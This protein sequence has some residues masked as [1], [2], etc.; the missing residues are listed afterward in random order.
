MASRLGVQKFSY[1]WQDGQKCV[2]SRIVLG[3][4]SVS[5]LDM[6]TAYATIANH[7]VKQDPTPV[8]KVTEPDGKVLVDYTQPTGTPV[9]NAAIADTT[10]DLLRGVVEGGTGRRA[11]IGRPAAGKTGTTDN[12]TDIWF[13]GY[14]PQLVAAVWMG[15]ADGQYSLGNIFGGD[16]AAATWAA[17]MRPAMEGQPELDFPAPGPL[18]APKAG[19]GEPARKR[20]RQQSIA[21]FPTDCGGPCV[22]MPELPEPAAPPTTQPTDGSSTTTTKPQEDD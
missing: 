22:R 11:N 9:L 8:V 2:S 14:T 19:A 4:C 20:P 10:T 13:V 5:P 3:Q 18:P 16:L 17:F 12:S 7:G 21:R 15:H 1:N 6:A